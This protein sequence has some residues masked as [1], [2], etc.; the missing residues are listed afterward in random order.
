MAQ[1]LVTAAQVDDLHTFA[2]LAFTGLLK[3][4]LGRHDVFAGKVGGPIFLAFDNDH[5]LLGRFGGDR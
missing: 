2:R 4:F 1:V 3:V 5:H